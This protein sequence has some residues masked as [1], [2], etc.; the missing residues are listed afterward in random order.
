MITLI[1]NYL[2]ELEKNR[3]YSHHSIRAYRKD[4]SAFALHLEGR[5]T[6]ILQ[7]DFRDVRDFVYE[8]Y[9]RGN[10]A[11]TIGRK[12][13][14]IRGLYRHL[15]AIGKLDRDP[16]ELVSSPREKRRLPESRKAISL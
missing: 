1:E 14:A 9:R 12:L 8:I 5:K 3:R 7:A 13:A 4:L 6:Q 10:S 16:T 2:R 15:M 11:R